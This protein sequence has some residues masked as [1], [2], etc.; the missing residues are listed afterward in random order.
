VREW[1]VAGGIIRDAGGLLLVQNRRRNGSLDWST[2]GGV[3][4]E[5]ETMLQG[6]AREIQE[7]TGLVVEEWNDLAYEIDVDFV[8]SRMHLRVE[9]HVAGA[10]TGN[11]VVDDPDGIVVDAGFKTPAEVTAHLT[12]APRWVAEPLTAWLDDPAQVDF[13]YQVRGEQPASW[14]VERRR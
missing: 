14:T 3:I 11:L 8:D 10:W 6:L 9:A 4:D 13:G 5:G 2:P 12:D 7:E 1:L